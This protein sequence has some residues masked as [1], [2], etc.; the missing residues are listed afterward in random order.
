MTMTITATESVLTDDLLQHC[1]ERAPAYDRENRFFA[2]DFEELRSAGYLKI[3]VP[4][5]FGG[6]GFNLSQ[7][8]QEQRRLAYRSPAT[9][10]ATNMHLYWTGV[11]ADLWRTGDRSCQ[12]ILEE[13]GRGEV[14][15]AGH[16]EVGNDFPLMAAVAK[17]KPVQG[18]YTLH[19]RKIFGSL[20][21]VWTRL[22]VH[23]LDDSNPDEPKIVHAFVSRDAEGYSIRETWDV[24]G[25]RATRS[26]DTILDGVFVDDG[27]IA[28]VVPAGLAGA[29]NFVL[30]VFAWAEPT[31][32][33]I[34]H[35]IA[36][37]AFD[38]AVEGVKRKT[39]IAMG[40]RSMAYNPMYQ[41]VIADMMAEQEAVSTHIDKIAEDWSNGVDHGGLW[42][43]KLVCLKYHATDSAKK[44][45]DMAMELSGGTGMF[46]GNE[47]ERLYRDVRCG[48]FHPANGP[49]MHEI[50]GKTALGIL[51]EEPRWG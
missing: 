23:A 47:L 48:G 15:A 39:S 12:W 8:C 37:R 35:A 16:G 14:F 10:L 2:E 30:G 19:G 46:K 26:D 29:D 4:T 43:A 24:L 36:Q 51:G 22:G 42:P 41:H 17:A 1:A 28:R 20:T 7:V 25:M 50:V 13:A 31:F 6:R 32:S 44:V 9:A 40:G 11:A 18:G 5:E 34:Y 27:H 33:S 38:L 3:A 45:V 21:P 49:L